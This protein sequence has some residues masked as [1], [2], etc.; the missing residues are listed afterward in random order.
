MQVAFGLGVTGG[1]C[2]PSLTLRL[3][4]GNSAPVPPPTLRPWIDTETWRDTSKWSD[5]A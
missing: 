2:R 1:A 4:A 5:R 3:G